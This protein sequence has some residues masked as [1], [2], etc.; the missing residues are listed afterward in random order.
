MARGLVALATA[1]QAGRLGAAQTPR[2]AA[3][4][5]RVARRALVVR[6]VAQ[7]TAL[8]V[9]Q[10]RVTRGLEPP[11]LEVRRLLK[12]RPKTR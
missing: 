7:T 5:L 9:V 4:G 8:Q 2:V 3:T 1:P 6:Q 11:A 12:R 10:T